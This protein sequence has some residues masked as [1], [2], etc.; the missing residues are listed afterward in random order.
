[1]SHCTDFYYSITMFFPP[2]IYNLWLARLFNE[3]HALKCIYL[4]LIYFKQ[5]IYVCVYVCMYVLNPNAILACY[6]LFVMR[7]FQALAFHVGAGVFPAGLV[8]VHAVTS[9]SSA[10]DLGT[11]GLRCCEKTSF[12]NYF[13]CMF[14]FYLYL[15]F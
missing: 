3:S 6:L 8:S 12:S 11:F 7:M 13:V 5:L 4:C 2:Q 10:L 1:M 14:N 15:R 9:C